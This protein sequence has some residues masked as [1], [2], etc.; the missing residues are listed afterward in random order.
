MDKSNSKEFSTLAIVSFIS[1][2]GSLFSFFVLPNT[3]KESVD[4]WL[5]LA[6]FLFL[7][8]LV[9]A[10]I[11]IRSRKQVEG[12]WLAKISVVIAIGFLFLIFSLALVNL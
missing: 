7:V 4:Y 11:V 9:S 12:R 6:T 8:S 2:I 10:M 5:L 3:H 1:I